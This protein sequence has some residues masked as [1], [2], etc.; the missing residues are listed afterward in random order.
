[1]K[2]ILSDLYNQLPV[3]VRVFFDSVFNPPPHLNRQKG[4]EKIVIDIFRNVPVE[5]VVETGSFRGGS[6]EFFAKTFKLPVHSVELNPVY[7]RYV[8]LRLSNLKGLH[9]VQSDS[10]D[11]LRKLTLEKSIASKFPFFYLDAHWW[12]DLPLMEEIRI[13]AKAW[14]KFVVLVDDF[15][16]P[17]DQ[18]YGFDDYGAG[19]ILELQSFREFKN[20][21]LACFFPTLPSSEET[22]LKRGCVVFSDTETANILKKIESLREFSLANEQYFRD[23]RA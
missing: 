18:G 21:N 23:A 6:T 1:M 17:G 13:I 4:R 5:V 20:L 7:H 2:K 14:C 19:K 3:P 9:L 8:C 12:E 16:V 10:R 11:F 15:R 22:G